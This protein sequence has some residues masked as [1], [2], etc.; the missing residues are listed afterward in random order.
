[1]MEDTTK[2]SVKIVFALLGIALSVIPLATLL[3][4]MVITC[5]IEVFEITIPLKVWLQAAGIIIV[6]GLLVSWAFWSCRFIGSH[7]RKYN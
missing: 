3:V 5:A 2:Y 1:M 7:R 4:F 6:F